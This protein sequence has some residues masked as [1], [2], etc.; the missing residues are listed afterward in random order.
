M[1]GDAVVVMIADE[2]DNCHD[3]VR[4]WNKLNEGYDCVLEAALYPVAAC[5]VILI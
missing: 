4:Y 2:S 5:T 1:I 3:V